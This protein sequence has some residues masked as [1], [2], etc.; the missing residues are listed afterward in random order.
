MQESD[1]L[2]NIDAAQLRA[3]GE[4]KGTQIQYF[5]P[6]F[7][8]FDWFTYYD[9][10][11]E[12]K[13]EANST[14]CLNISYD[15]SIKDNPLKE[16][17]NLLHK[18]NCKCNN[19]EKYNLKEKSFGFDNLALCVYMYFTKIKDKINFLKLDVEDIATTVHY[20]WTLNYLWWRDNKP[21]E[22]SEYIKPYNPLGD[23]R[24]DT[25]AITTYTEL[26]E[27]EKEK[28][29]IIARWLLDNIK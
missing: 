27:D 4:H 8:K 16:W 14:A 25:L 20:V 13:N 12:E 9:K 6:V 26:P 19:W 18:H 7:K 5:N 21:F 10:F 15:F 22:N 17:V 23:E 29:R 2:I 3:L 28:D 24:R 1:K 11:P